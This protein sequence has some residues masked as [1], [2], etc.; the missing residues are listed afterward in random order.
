MTGLVEGEEETVEGFIG[1]RF[2][3]QSPILPTLIESLSQ[4]REEA[5]LQANKPL[6]QAIKIIMNSLYGVLGS[7]GCVFHD[8]KLASSITLRG[9]EIMKQTRAWIE[10]LGYQ[11]IYG[12]TDSTFVWLGD[13]GAELVAKQVGES[14]VAT[15]NNRWRDKL[16][17]EFQLECFLELEF[18]SHYEQFFMPTLRG[19]TEGSK[20][21]YVGA[22]TNSNDELQLIFKGME[23]VR[24][25]W[26]PLARRVQAELYYRLFAKQDLMVYLQEVVNDLMQGGLDDELVFS[27][28][29]RRDIEDYTAKS[30]PHVKAARLMYERTG[31]ERYS[32][33]GAK[34]DYVITLNGAEPIRY[35]QSLIDYH[36]YL[37][38]QLAPIAE[39]VLGIL[40]QQ[41]SNIA[42]KQMSLI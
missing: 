8:A 21:R 12:D 3:R 2:S 17:K 37:N 35:R 23:Q 32:K 1:A 15:I 28:R 30:S 14:I 5:K 13:K 34:V 29:L 20:K 7:Q 19:S 40:N 18:E 36:Y 33:K 31:E 26:S 42:S 39:P 6:S 11:V 25:D 27:K 9:H 16:T 22:Y 4:R 38:K 41:F 24:S 10:G